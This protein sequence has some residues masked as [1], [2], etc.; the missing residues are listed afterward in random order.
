M[1]TKDNKTDFKTSLPINLA[2]HKGATLPEQQP[3]A[4]Y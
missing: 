4:N 2:M 3:I 1:Y